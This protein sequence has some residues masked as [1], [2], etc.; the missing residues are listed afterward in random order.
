MEVTPGEERVLRAICQ[1][2]SPLGVGALGLARSLG[3]T[4]NTV[5]T[6]AVTL[7]RK[8]YCTRERIGMRIFLRAS[9]AGLAFVLS[10]AEADASPAEFSKVSS[11]G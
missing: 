7:E 3:V 2:S 9:P 11:A 1:S 4:R 6:I 10:R 8:G 5:S